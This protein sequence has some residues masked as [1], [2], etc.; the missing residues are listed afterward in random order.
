[1]TWTRIIG[2]NKCETCD[3]T[4]FQVYGTAVY[5]ISAVDAGL[6][7]PVDDEVIHFRLT[8]RKS[9][10]LYAVF[11][12]QPVLIIVVLA[13]TTSL[14]STPLSNGFRLISIL[15]E[16]DR[17]SLDVLGGASFSAHLDRIVR[18]GVHTDNRNG[19]GR[20]VRYQIDGGSV[21]RDKVVHRTTYG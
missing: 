13:L 2:L 1:M 7:Y 19:N 17:N 3:L 12:V 21:V 6:L 11:A 18:L 8:L 5:N 20:S 14:Y 15:A 10:A 16:V 9:S 4:Q